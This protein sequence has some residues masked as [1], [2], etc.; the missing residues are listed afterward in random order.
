MQ[1]FLLTIELIPDSIQLLDMPENP[2]MLH[3]YTYPSDSATSP[4]ELGSG[5]STPQAEVVMPSLV[6][7]LQKMHGLTKKKIYGSQPT[8]QPFVREERIRDKYRQV[9]TPLSIPSASSPPP[10]PK[11]PSADLRMPLKS[12]TDRARRMSAQGRITNSTPESI[13]NSGRRSPWFRRDS[14]PVLPTDSGSGSYPSSPTS[15][16]SLNT[17]SPAL[18]TPHD[19]DTVGTTAIGTVSA[20]WEPSWLEDQTEQYSSTNASRA[21]PVYEQGIGV[22][23]YPRSP[24]PSLTPMSSFAPEREKLESTSLSTL[25]ANVEQHELIGSGDQPFIFSPEYEAAATARFQAIF[26]PTPLRTET[27]DLTSRNSYPETASASRRNYY[28]HSPGNLS[29]MSF[30]ST[31]ANLSYH[32]PSQSATLTATKHDAPKSY[33]S[34]GSSSLEGWDGRYPL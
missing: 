33:V 24:L 23:E 2:P 20:P 9:P 4:T 14:R 29:P 3:S 16:S 15:V 10:I 27:P 34:G 28:Y 19:F 22:T 8:R 7:R 13:G 21:D 32:I 26:Q 18:P 12:K 25:N 5:T 11:S 31:L 1:Y 30:S 17:N 6:S